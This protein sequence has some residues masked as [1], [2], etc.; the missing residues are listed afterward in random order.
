MIPLTNL[1][2][3][4]L[5]KISSLQTLLGRY[6]VLI[7]VDWN[8]GNS[9]F[10]FMLNILKLLGI[11][12]EELLDWIAN[13]LADKKNGANGILSA[14]EVAIKSIILTTFKNT[15]TC[16][17][18]PSLPDFIMDGGEG[19]S[20]NLSDI[21]S[22][23][24]LGNCPTDKEGSIF[25]FDN[26]DYTPSNIYSSTD[27]NA[28]LWYVINKGRTYSF[29]TNTGDKGTIWDNRVSFKRKFEK[30]GCLDGNSTTDTTT[31]KG[32]FFAKA[33]NG[34]AVTVI[35]SVGVRKEIL[36]CEY[37]DA[38]VS[39]PEHLKVYLNPARYKRTALPN[40]TIF[41][42]NADYIFSLQLFD[43]KTILTQLVNSLL[44]IISNISVNFTI[45]RD[46]MSQMLSGIVSKVIEAD[47]EDVIEDCYFSF[48]NEEYDAMMEQAMLNFS[49][50]YKSGN[51]EN[52]NIDINT[53]E[54]IDNLYKVGTAEDLNEDITVIKN[55]IRGIA[56]S[57]SSTP[58]TSPKNK[59]KFEFDFLYKLLNELT[60][61][62]AMQILS[63]KVMLLYAINEKVMNPDYDFSISGI[64]NFFKSFK[65]LMVSIVKQIKN[66]ILSELY[67]FV[68]SQIQDLINLFIQKLLLEKIYYYKLIITDALMWYSTV[69]ATGVIGLGR[70]RQALEIDSVSRADIV[71]VQD[72]P[73][74]D[75]SC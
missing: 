61:Q 5:G 75:I 16:A 1:R 56:S 74:E 73:P 58:E 36:R 22:F 9:S 66:T 45:E 69:G 70:N 72:N 40:K 11:N 12:E 30:A 46:V 27:F 49:G 42:F 31:P 32:K 50:T 62:L 48:S 8:T 38:G 23:G 20:I 68:K 57:L 39:N 6:P 53:D 14:I 18:N 24:I 28:Y 25:Y 44:G 59:I 35:K 13:L 15:Y 41:E 63:P 47:D 3:D 34:T 60:V 51:E 19:V 37:F 55:T 43:T 71:P 2:N 64:K 67:D 21:D 65:N 17:I 29:N 54:I 26:V 4:V 33:G 52:E 7:S 10:S